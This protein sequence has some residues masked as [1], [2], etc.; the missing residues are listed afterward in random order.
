MQYE[1]R[2]QNWSALFQPSEWVLQTVE[3]IW[4][5]STVKGGEGS[6]CLTEAVPKSIV[7][8]MIYWS[9][10]Y[11]TVRCCSTTQIMKNSY[12]KIKFRIKETAAS[13]WKVTGRIMNLY[14][15]GREAA[16]TCLYNLIV[17]LYLIWNQI[18]ICNKWWAGRRRKVG[19]EKTTK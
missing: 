14:F 11:V 5:D 1:A 15:L 17:D 2:R 10:C 7:Q 19:Q 16:K 13:Y 8:E 6:H 3:V 9:D 18:L 4:S 12:W